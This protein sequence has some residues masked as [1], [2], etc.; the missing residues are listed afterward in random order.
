LAIPPAVQASPRVH[1]PDEPEGIRPGR[2]YAQSPTTPHPVQQFAPDRPKMDY[3]SDGRAVM[4]KRYA[5][6]PHTFAPILDFEVGS[7]ARMKYRANKDGLHPVP[8]GRKLLRTAG[9]DNLTPDQQRVLAQWGQPDWLRGPF[10][11]T[12][13]DTATEWLY[14]RQN[15]IFQWVDGELVY[16]GPVTDVERTMLVHGA[17][18][19]VIITYLE[20]NTRRETFIYRD[21]FRSMGRE[22]VFSFSNGRLIFSQETP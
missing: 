10:R 21:T 3:R 7:M 11:T 20:P 14:E 12:R 9:K 19:H 1:Q 4:V 16:Q 18:T 2:S 17:P 8:A 5:N 22:K 15:R 13:G 6:T